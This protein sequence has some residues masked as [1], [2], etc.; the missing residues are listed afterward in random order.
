MKNVFGKL[1]APSMIVLLLV[2]PTNVLA[3]ERRGAN[4]IVTRLDGSQVSGELIAVKRESL[5]LLSYGRD[6]SIDLADVKTVRIIKKSLAG[7]GALYGFLAGAVGGAG[8]GLAMGRTDML[9][10]KTPLVL[11][12][13]GGAIGA[14][15]GLLVGSVLGLDS[16]FSVAGK[17][18]TV[19]N[20]YWDKLRAHARV[21]R[22]P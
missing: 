16:S 2:I 9:E 19:V 13:F 10:E 15:S 7:K 17:P 8:V 18:E 1:I 6:E 14:L 3:K 11:G 22:L 5:L 21:P 12:V 4:L 20:E